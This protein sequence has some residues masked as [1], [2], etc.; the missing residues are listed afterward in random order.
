MLA[1]ESVSVP[2]P[3]LVSPVAPLTTADTVKP[4]AAFVVVKVRV[5]APIERLPLMLALLAP[6][7]DV[8]LPPKVRVPAPVV[9]VPPVIPLFTA[10]APIVSEKPFKS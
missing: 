5:A 7:V 8:T 3:A 9:T 6:P 4:S 10:R 2:L 1:P